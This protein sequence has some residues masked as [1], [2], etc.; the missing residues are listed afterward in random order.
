LGSTIGNQVVLA[1]SYQLSVIQF[2]AMSELQLHTSY[3]LVSYSLSY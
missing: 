2:W 3:F 1:A